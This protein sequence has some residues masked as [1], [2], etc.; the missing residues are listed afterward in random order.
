LSEPTFSGPVVVTGASGY[1][2]SWVVHE[3]L[4]RG[5]TVRGTVR[6][7]NHPTKTAH[8]RAMADEL[9]GTLELFAADLLQEGSFA[10]ALTG[11]HTVI[12]TAS[13][14]HSGDGDPTVTLVQPALD[15]TA[16]VLNQATATPSVQR[17]VLTSSVLAVYGDATESE[18]RPLTEAD[19][20][21][22]SSAEHQPYAYSKTVAERKAWELARAQSQW[23]LV[24]VNPAFVMGP[25]LSGRKDSTSMDFLLN[26]LKGTWKSGT[27]PMSSGFVDVR[28]VATAHVEAALRHDAD[29][30][31][32]LSAQVMTFYAFGQLI[33]AA[34]PGRFGVPRREVPKL[35]ATLAAPFIGFTRRYVRDNAGH[36]LAFDNERSRTA[37]GLAY[38]PVEET[39][40][41]MVEQV[42]ADGLVDA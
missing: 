1:V 36:A 6:D 21:E 7:P 39:V 5:A 18:G 42:L 34:Y 13:P 32:I 11:A 27:L 38:R 35:L 22:T 10:E 23:S 15:G 9:P 41:D 29:G 24:V 3:L 33:E 20:N 12:H 31:H 37:L 26:N 16:N 2:A 40:R 4:A 8:L 25:S 14:F 17:V 28:D 19:W 30:R